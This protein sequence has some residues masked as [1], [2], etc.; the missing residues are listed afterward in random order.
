MLELTHFSHFS[1]STF[2]ITK[3]SSPNSTD[4]STASSTTS[5]TSKA[6]TST[7]TTSPTPKPHPNDNVE[8]LY[9]PYIK[10]HSDYESDNTPLRVKCEHEK[11]FFP[12]PDNADDILKGVYERRRFGFRHSYLPI[13]DQA[14]QFTTLDSHLLAKKLA[15]L[16]YKYEGGTA[17]VFKLGKMDSSYGQCRHCGRSSWSCHEIRFGKYCNKAVL[18]HYKNIRYRGVTPEDAYIVFI[19]FYNRA[20]EFAK[21]DELESDNE[22]TLGDAAHSHPA[23]CMDYGSL[24]RTLEWAYWKQQRNYE[25]KRRASRGNIWYSTKK[26]EKATNKVK[27][28]GSDEKVK[29][30]KKVSV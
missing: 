13:D 2:R 30:G 14:L 23:K 16:L 27:S 20:L 19:N 17:P 28:T 6:S 25:K 1:S 10:H 29:E 22:S 12:P 8:I 18:R 11:S 7:S 15:S 21:F 24:I 3:M 4:K 9:K 26:K 5:P